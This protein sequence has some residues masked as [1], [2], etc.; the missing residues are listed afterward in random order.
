MRYLLFSQKF[1]FLE[2]CY[3][4]KTHAVSTRTI[5]ID[6]IN[7]LFCFYYFL[8]GV[9]MCVYFVCRH[10]F[11][12]LNP[13]CTQNRSLKIHFSTVYLV[14]I[15]EIF[16]LSYTHTHLYIYIYIYIYILEE[17]VIRLIETFLCFLLFPI[18]LNLSS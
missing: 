1:T 3:P 10:L 6:C 9:D 14:S 13:S 15:W 11:F 2:L 17:Q 16:Y 4:F 12:L 18:S 7:H 5:F 8:K